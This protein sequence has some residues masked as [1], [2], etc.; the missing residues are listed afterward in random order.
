[1]SMIAWTT[2][3]QTDAIVGFGRPLTGRWIDGVR[4]STA[5][6]TQRLCE[7]DAEPRECLPLHS[8]PHRRQCARASR[9][10]DG[11]GLGAVA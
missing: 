2:T 6:S 1:M 5:S 9:T 8:V 10:P 11:V 3:S 7:P 4:N